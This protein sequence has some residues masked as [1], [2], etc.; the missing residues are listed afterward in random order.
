MDTA[1]APAYRAVAMAPLRFLALLLVTAHVVA[2][3]APCPPTLPT[4]A[5]GVAERSSEL[6][7]H[8]E[9]GCGDGTGAAPASSRVG[10][11]VARALPALPQGTRPAVLVELAPRLGDPPVF[12]IDPIPV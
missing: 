9:C 10:F 8:C 6:K 11:G 4:D 5:G 1:G 12:D 2:A 7:K 3:S